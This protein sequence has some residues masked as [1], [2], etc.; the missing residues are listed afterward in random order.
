MSYRYFISLIFASHPLPCY[1]VG[2]LIDKKGKKMRKNIIFS[3]VAASALIILGQFGFF[4]AL[5]MFFVAGIIPG[6]Q[7]SLPSGL[8]F[9]LTMACIALVITLLARHRI[10]SLIEEKIF[11]PAKTK[12]NLPKR[13][14]G[15]I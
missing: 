1:S 2:S 12:K 9:F 6:T 10:I 11:P 15:E 7:Y 4:N 8:M 13:R 14:F 3:C 5:L